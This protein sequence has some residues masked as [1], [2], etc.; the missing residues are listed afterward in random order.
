[1]IK[2]KGFLFMSLVANPKHSFTTVFYPM[3]KAMGELCPPDNTAMG[4]NTRCY[5]ACPLLLLSC[6]RNP[7]RP[8]F[9]LE[10]RVGKQVNPLRLPPVPLPLRYGKFARM[11][12]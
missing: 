4:C 2:I 10:H 5:A 6:A 8:V 7:W 9:L 1:M 12:R 3:A 11:Q